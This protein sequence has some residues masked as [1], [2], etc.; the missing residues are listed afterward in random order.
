VRNRIVGIAE[1]SAVSGD[2]IDVEIGVG[3]ITTPA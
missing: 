3:F 1:V 2:I